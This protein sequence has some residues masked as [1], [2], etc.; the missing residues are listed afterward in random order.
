[1]PQRRPYSR[2]PPKLAA[3]GAIAIVFSVRAFHRSAAMIAK[4]KKPA[5]LRTTVA[6][7]FQP[8]ASACE[9]RCHAVRSSRT[10][11]CETLVFA[12][13]NLAILIREK[14]NPRRFHRLA[15]GHRKKLYPARQVSLQGRSRVERDAGEHHKQLPATRPKKARAK[16]FSRGLADPSAARFG[17]FRKERPPPRA[18]AG[19]QY[20]VAKVPRC[21]VSAAPI[22]TPFS[23]KMLCAEPQAS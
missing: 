14:E 7:S 9:I 19:P 11:L 3:F 16:N 22:N 10:F 18:A 2:F 23:R 21:L 8:V 13:D 4:V 1:M 6:S 12:A 20:P 5:R 15:I 17:Q